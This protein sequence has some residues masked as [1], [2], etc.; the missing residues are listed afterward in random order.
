VRIVLLREIPEE[1][2]L[3]GRW[4]DLLQQMERPEVFYTC[5]WA[6]AIQA[7]FKS[8]FKPPPRP[9]LFL[10]Y[11]GGE[12]V[13]VASLS[14]A[15]GG[16]NVSFLAGTT[17]DYCE[18]LSH[19]QRREEF[20]GAVFGELRRLGVGDVVLA[21]LPADSATAAALPAAAKKHG[22]HVYVRPAYLCPH[23]EMGSAAEREELKSVVMGK[24]QVRRCLRA[25]E[26]EGPV[27]CRYLRS[28][29]QIRGALPDFV[30]AHVARFQA[31]RRISILCAPERRFLLEELARR[32]SDTGIVTLTSLMM[33][34][35]PVAWSYGF[36]FHGTW[37]LYQTTFDIR[38]EENSPGYCLLA[39]V[40]MEA[41]GM[42]TVKRVDL[43][44]GSEE[45]K[46]WFANSSRQTLHA[47]LTTSPVRHLRE[48][49]RYRIATEVR[50]FPRLEAAI[51]NTQSRLRVSKSVN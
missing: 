18:F 51:R 29:T 8:A 27:T 13:G 44:L 5:E 4:N 33:G 7:A 1:P 3:Q 30:D 45:Y 22:F 25:L 11:D 32:F 46:G 34:D 14:L 23:V 35:R 43:G 12:L 28:W 38:C 41:C 50:A 36:Q 40:V 6:L 31:V 39:K 47:S 37:F 26:S 9:L 19:P 42:N 21:N 20:V 17:A 10:A 16:P 48:M 15:L 49:A 2:S 24:R